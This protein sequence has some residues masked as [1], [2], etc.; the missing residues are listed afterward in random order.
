MALVIAADKD[1]N[2]THISEEYLEQY[3]DSG[4]HKVA[5]IVDDEVVYIKK[6]KASSDK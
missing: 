4:L 5:D 2:E 3:P 6:A 1:G